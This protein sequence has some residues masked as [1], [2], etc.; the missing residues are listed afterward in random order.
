MTGESKRTANEITYREAEDALWAHYGLER[1]KE[2]WIEIPSEG[3]RVRVQE[4][5]EGPPILFVH[6]GPNAGSTFV[7]LVA[8]LP[9]RRCLMLDRPGTGLSDPVEYGAVDRLPQL[10]TRVVAAVLDG[11]DVASADLAGSSFG[12]SW[13]IWFA[14]A[15]PDRVNRLTLLGAP[16]FVPGMII[17]GFVKLMMMPII[18]NLISKL[19]PT[20]GSAKRIHGMLG[21]PKTTVKEVIPD[22]YWRW[23]VALAAKTATFDHDGAAMTTAM[24]RG[25]DPGV[26]M[27]TELL[28][29]ISAPTTL[30]WG[31]G[32]TFGGEGVARQLA[33]LIP[34]ADLVMAQ[35]GHLPW[36]DDPAATADAMR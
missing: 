23:G 9:E 35:G 36:L 22:A 24:S 25:V 10:A 20:A 8:Q 11:L 12:G 28:G 33:D 34:R 31:D 29:S 27:S 32:D 6:G 7:P 3:T 2:H 17:P 5:G 21:H 4:V 13:A 1:A 15:H 18:G 26:Q 14:A 30:Y 16:A 19:P